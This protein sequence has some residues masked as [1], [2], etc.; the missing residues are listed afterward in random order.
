MNIIYIFSVIIL[1]FS[2]TYHLNFNVKIENIKY[3]DVVH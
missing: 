2:L 1:L 3:T